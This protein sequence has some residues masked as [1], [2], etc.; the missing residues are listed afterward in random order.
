MDV[1]KSDLFE[2]SAITGLGRYSEIAI[3]IKR[4]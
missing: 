1:A 2:D 3:E 4:V